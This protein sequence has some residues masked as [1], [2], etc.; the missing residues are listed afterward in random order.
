MQTHVRKLTLALAACTLLVAGGASAQ[1]APRILLQPTA[2]KAARQA[3][4]EP[5]VLHRRN[6]TA[7]IGL[8][9]EGEFQ[10]LTLP[11][12]DG[13]ITVELDRMERVGE[14]GEVWHGKVAKQ[15]RSIAT[16]AVVGEVLVGNVLTEDGQA[17]EIRYLGEGVHTLSEVDLSRMPNEAQPRHPSPAGPYFPLADT[18]T[19]DPPS[20]IDVMVVYTDDAR[21][22][23]GGTL[24]MKATVYLAVAETNQSYLNSGITQRIRLVHVAEVSYTEGAGISTYLT[25]L[26]S[27]DSVIDNVQTLRD[28]YAADNVVMIVEDDS[29]ACGLGYFMDPVSNSFEAYAY[30]VVARSCATGYFSFGHELGHNMSA[31]HDCANA[32]STGPYPYNRG[33]VELSPASYPTIARWRTVMAYNGSPSSAR[34]PYW[35][36]PL[37]NYPSTGGDPTGGSCPTPPYTA[38]NRQVLNNTA[39]TVANFRCSSPGRTDVWMK[40]TWSDTGVEPDPL[41]ASQPMSESPYLWVRNFQD[42]T[43]VHQHEH[44]NPDAGQLN[45]VYVKM[46]NGGSTAASGNLEV[47][48]TTASTSTSWSG[49]WTMIANIPVSGFAAH[50]TKIVEGSWTPTVTGHFCLMARWVSTADPMAYTETTDI[51]YNARQN[52][53]IIWRNVEIVDFLDQLNIRASLQVRNID[54]VRATTARLEIRPHAEEVATSFIKLGQVEVTFDERLLEV[55][56]AGGSKGSGFRETKDGFLLTDPAGAT[57]ENLNLGPDFTGVLGMSFT[58]NEATPRAQ[59]YLGVMQYEAGRGDAP[60]GGVSYEIHTD[61]D[62][63]GRTQK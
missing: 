52:N 63:S 42:T 4:Q 53:N 7:D 1:T 9:R 55:W 27:T 8:L 26:Q 5:R 24:A 35:S 11:V 10:T 44:Q 2:L 31:D 40:D 23:A 22:A 6:V 60:I 34:L 32:G 50:S 49:G 30:A 3:V 48:I 13:E 12:F 16:L 37:V 14:D 29:T 62:K 36:N 15:P 33:W 46:H 20:S 54:T 25:N 56:K 51:N 38:N 47:Y 18:C 43:L 57:F 19:T 59:Y 21:A 45:Y 61:R 28:T 58:R 41:T 17:F 39:A